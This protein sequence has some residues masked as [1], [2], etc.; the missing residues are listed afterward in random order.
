MLF[1]LLERR[2]SLLILLFSANKKLPTLEDIE[3]FIIAIVSYIKLRREKTIS[4]QTITYV[5][6]YIINT[7]IFYY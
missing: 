1:A 3:R 4:T 2:Y 5:V 7:L 6:S